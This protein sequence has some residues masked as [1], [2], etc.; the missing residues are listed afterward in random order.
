MGGSWEVW[1]IGKERKGRKMKYI[2]I[3]EN[4]CANHYDLSTDDF[5]YID[6]PVVMS[7]KAFEKL[8]GGKNVE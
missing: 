4:G 1:F 2:L 6:T 8:I 3:D 7:L 5:D